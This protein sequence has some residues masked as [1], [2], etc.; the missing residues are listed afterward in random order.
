MNDTTLNT[1]LDIHPDQTREAATPT[2]TAEI[3][4]VESPLPL[5]PA[6]IVT[7]VPP[8][9]HLK[10]LNDDVEFAREQIKLLIDDGRSAMNGALELAA[11]DDKPRAYEVVATLLTAVVQANKELILLHKTRKETL[12]ADK[13]TKTGPPVSV[14]I[15]KAVFFGRASD[16]LRELQAVKKQTA[17]ALAAKPDPHASES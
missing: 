15:D 6:I 2:V 17:A 5:P 1:V 10:D 14:E 9:P 4:P 7:P 3:L 11:N 12:K 16:L 13:D 8:D